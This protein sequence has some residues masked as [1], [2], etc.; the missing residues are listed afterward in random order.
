MKKCP[1]LNLG[2]K[3]GKILEIRKNSLEKNWKLGKIPKIRKNRKSWEKYFVDKVFRKLR[4]NT[5]KLGKILK[6]L[7]KIV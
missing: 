7:G 4:K 5:K 3:L 6:K 1:H 2:K